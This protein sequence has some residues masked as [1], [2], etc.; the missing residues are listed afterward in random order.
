MNRSG[1]AG[2]VLATKEER[3]I[4]EL[5]DQ[6]QKS[7]NSPRARKGQEKSDKLELKCWVRRGEYVGQYRTTHGEAQ[8]HRTL[9]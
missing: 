5:N 3:A 8:G 1:P 2:N 6:D 9:Y 4:A 7:R